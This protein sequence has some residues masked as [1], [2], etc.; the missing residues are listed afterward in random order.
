MG[1]SRSGLPRWAER[2]RPRRCR[3]C[4]WRR[5]RELH[6]WLWHARWRSGRMSPWRRWV[7]KRGPVVALC[8]SCHARVTR[9][10]AKPWTS[11]PFVTGCVILFGWARNVAVV[12]AILLVLRA[13]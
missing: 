9:W 8:T 4:W 12:L 1:R 7:Q 10:D 5:G 2:H 3:A 6:H 11:L 13:V